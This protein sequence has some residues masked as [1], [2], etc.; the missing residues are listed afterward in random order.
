MVPD[1]RK[2]LEACESDLAVGLA[3]KC[4]SME[5]LAELLESA[6][7]AEPPSHIRDGGVIRAGF[8]DEL[9]RLRSI[10][11]DG[12]SWLAEYQQKE[13]R[14]TGIAKLKVGFNKV[15]GYYIEVSHFAADKV[16]GDYVRKQTIKNAE[17]YITE[18]LKKYE[19][20]ILTAQEK[21]I[22][23]EQRLFEKVRTE[24]TKYISRLQASLTALRISIV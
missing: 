10:S 19:E 6:I 17:R 15:F 24:T 5:E 20:E 16:P 12:R 11:K 8:N 2:I 18:E 9:D 13:S 23:L 3:G 21:A 22:E 14:R 1:L 4:D 7:V